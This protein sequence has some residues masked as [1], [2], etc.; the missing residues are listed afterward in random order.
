MGKLIITKLDRFN[1][2][3]IKQVGGKFFLSAQDSLVIDIPGL[4]FI[5]KY[6]VFNNLISVKVLEGI[7]NE[8]RDIKT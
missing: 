5:L 6:L 7:I 2:I 4:A 1:T 3:V 8:Y